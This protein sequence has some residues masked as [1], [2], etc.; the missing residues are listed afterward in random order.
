VQDGDA[1]LRGAL[2]G[3]P[4]RLLDGGQGPT[5]A[6]N[7][8]SLV[9]DAMDQYGRFDALLGNAVAVEFAARF[10][11]SRASNK[12][13][14]MAYYATEEVL[15]RVRDGSVLGAPTD[16]P[17]VQARIAID[18]AVRALQGESIPQR[19]SPLIEVLDRERLKTFDLSRTLPPSKQWMVQKALP[20]N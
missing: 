18:L 19:V 2:H 11:T 14:L 17:V 12:P 10:F 13:L 1:G 5:D 6:K 16:Q 15:A 3:K 4:V 20:P 8:A 9:R 7:Q